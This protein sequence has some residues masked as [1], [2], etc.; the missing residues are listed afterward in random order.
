MNFGVIYLEL[1]Y[2]SSDFNS[3]SEYLQLP[4][5]G[6]TFNF[7]LKLKIKVHRPIVFFCR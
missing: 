6:A 7:Y 4:V 3:N 2:Q 1:D 5:S